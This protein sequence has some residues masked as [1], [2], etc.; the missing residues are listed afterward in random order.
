MWETGTVVVP[1][2]ILA[3]LERHGHSLLD[4]EHMVTRGRVIDV[5][6]DREDKKTRVY[7]VIGSTIDGHPA[8]F[9]V[10]VRRSRGVVA[11]F[12]WLAR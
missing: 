6:T 2:S 12:T 7:E 11:Q 9:A 3:A 1:A 4:F 10:H 8:R 5:A